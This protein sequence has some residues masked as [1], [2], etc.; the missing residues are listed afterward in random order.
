M[1]VMGGVI[2]KRQGLGTGPDPAVTGI[3]ATCPARGAPRVGQL[4]Q[5]TSRAL[6]G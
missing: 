6:A 1:R 2:Q 4:Q 5:Q 3:P